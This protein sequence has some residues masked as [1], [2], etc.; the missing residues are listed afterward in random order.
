[1]EIM[2][3]VNLL[4]AAALIAVA[5]ETASS[6]DVTP[7]VSA[8]PAAQTAAPGAGQVP[9]WYPPR[10][11]GGGYAQPWQQP[12]QW[13]A[14]PRGEGQ[15]RPDYPPYGEFRP[16]DTAP[17]VNPLSATLRQTQEQLAAK[18]LELETTRTQLSTAQAKLQT[19]TAALQKAQTDTLNA[20]RQVD[21]TVAQ[22]ETLRHILCELTAR[23]GARNAALR[24]ALQTTVAE[25]DDPGS[26]AAGG[27]ET[28]TAEQA[29]PQIDLKCSQLSRYPAITSGQRGQTIAPQAGQTS[30]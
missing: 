10:P 18:T 4:L 27:A 3:P 28:A 5:A 15:P 30:D 16:A 21:T 23:L 12:S 14:T 2:P 8:A 29:K 11:Y 19:A 25:P 9:G 24:S 13:P 7:D 6:E 22:V 1:M 17:A 20:A 26:A